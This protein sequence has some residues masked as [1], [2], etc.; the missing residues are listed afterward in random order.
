[1]TCPDGI[2]VLTLVP[3]W[4]AAMVGAFAESCDAAPA[5]RPRLLQLGDRM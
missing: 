4:I 5:R 1:V 3:R 2:G